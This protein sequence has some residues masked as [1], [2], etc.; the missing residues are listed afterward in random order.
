MKVTMEKWEVERVKKIISDIL[1]LW[2]HDTITA[3]DD[4]GSVSMST[5][6]FFE[7]LESD[8]LSN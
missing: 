5:K 2:S 3:G 8:L 1:Q 6:T 4:N 7:A